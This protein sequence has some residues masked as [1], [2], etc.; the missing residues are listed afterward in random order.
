MIIGVR[1]TKEDQQTGKHQGT[2]GK[3]MKRMIVLV[4][5]IAA[6]AAIAITTVSIPGRFE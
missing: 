3:K 5:A 2:G 4:T 6:I 1:L